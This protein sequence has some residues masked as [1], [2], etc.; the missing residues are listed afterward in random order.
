M[1]YISIKQGHP[2]WKLLA[3]EHNKMGRFV[4]LPQHYSVEFTKQEIT[5]FKE[6]RLA[7]RM[8]YVCKRM[9]LEEPL[10]VSNNR[11]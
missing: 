9:Y 10:V 2:L 5:L 4:Y 1:K 8:V 3:V 6:Y 11:R 7:G